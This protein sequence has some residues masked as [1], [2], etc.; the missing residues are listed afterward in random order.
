[1]QV[2]DAATE[3]YPW[4]TSPSIHRGKTVAAKSTERI[5]TLEERLKPLLVDFHDHNSYVPQF[6]ISF[7]LAQRGLL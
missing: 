3:V 5:G 7:L 2:P 6:R 4:R 1:M